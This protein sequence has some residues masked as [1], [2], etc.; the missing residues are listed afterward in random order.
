[1]IEYKMVQMFTATCRV[2]LMWRLVSQAR[3]SCRKKRVGSSSYH[4]LWQKVLCMLIDLVTN[5]GV[6]LPF[7]A[8][9][10]RVPAGSSAFSEHVPVDVNTYFIRCPAADYAIKKPDGNLTRLLPLKS[11]WKSWATSK[12][13]HIYSKS[14]V[15]LKITLCIL[16]LALIS[17][18]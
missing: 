9:T 15:R 1:M 5:G 3:L 10:W 17:S 14:N 16:L 4:R 6:W 12:F 13:D 18:L 8:V 7:F 11:M 2:I